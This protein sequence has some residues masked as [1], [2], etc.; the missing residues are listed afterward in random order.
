MNGFTRRR[1]LGARP[2]DR[3]PDT[4][5]AVAR[6]S[7]G[8]V[9]VLAAG[10]TAEGEPPPPPAAACPHPAPLDGRLDPAMPNVMVLIRKETNVL[11]ASARIAKSYAIQPRVLSSIRMLVLTQITEELVG[12]LRCEPDIERLSYDAP[13]HIG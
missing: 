7:I 9:V 2:N 4:S 6:A 10:G 11:D 8:I 5:S 1:H 13:T 12:R 3:A